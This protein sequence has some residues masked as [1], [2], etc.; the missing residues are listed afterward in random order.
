MYTMVYTRPDV[1]YVVG[2]VS[3]YMSNPSEEH[4]KDVKWILRY[5]RGTID[6]ALLWGHIN[7]FA[8]LCRLGFSRR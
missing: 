4:W 6:T 8:R 1:A 5:L 2:V 7:Q 3:R